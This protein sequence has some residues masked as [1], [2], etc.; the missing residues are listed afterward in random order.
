MKQGIKKYLSLFVLGVFLFSYSEKGIHDLLHADDFHCH[1]QHA[2]H[3]HNLEHHCAICDFELS[4]YD[5]SL[6]FTAPSFTRCATDVS[7]LV[8]EQQ[9]AL[10]PSSS[11]SARGP[12]AIV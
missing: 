8:T 7:F 4:F 3:F 6:T 12:P 5:T 9:I 10:L 1:E 11:L 2:K